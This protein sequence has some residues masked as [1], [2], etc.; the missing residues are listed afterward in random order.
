MGK[1]SGA[2]G[3]R[4]RGAAKNPKDYGSNETNRG[5]SRYTNPAKNRDNESF[6]AEPSRD[7]TDLGQKFGAPAG[8][9]KKAASRFALSSRRA[10]GR[11]PANRGIGKE[12]VVY[13]TDSYSP[14]PRGKTNQRT[15]PG[16]RPPVGQE[17]RTSSFDKTSGSREKFGKLPGSS[18][19][20]FKKRSDGPGRGE[21]KPG[22]ARGFSKFSRNSSTDRAK[23]GTKKPK[24]PPVSGKKPGP[25]PSPKRF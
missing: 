2:M 15:S 14:S 4:S 25:K 6:S 24:N 18:A 23:P 16:G 22:A 5:K 20:G 17:Q 11:G 9:L 12:P 13:E 10:V 7:N 1:E 8:G 21:E 3:S 19:P